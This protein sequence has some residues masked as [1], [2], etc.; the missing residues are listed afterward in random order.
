MTIQHLYSNL[1][2]EYYEDIY[3]DFPLSDFLSLIAHIDEKDT[4]LIQLYRQSIIR[5]IELMIIPYNCDPDSK[6]K[7]PFQ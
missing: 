5:I 3:Y 7:N 6:S 1:N 2:S 4:E